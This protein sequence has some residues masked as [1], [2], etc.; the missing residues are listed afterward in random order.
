MS[1]LDVGCYTYLRVNQLILPHMGDLVL[2]QNLNF[3]TAEV[4]K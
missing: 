2:K 4:T 3:K 1:L